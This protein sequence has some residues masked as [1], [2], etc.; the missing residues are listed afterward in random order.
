MDEKKPK[1]DERCEHCRFWRRAEDA[2][3][4]EPEGACVRL[5]PTISDSGELRLCIP[6]PRTWGCGEY[7]DS[8]LANDLRALVNG[9]EIYEVAGVWL[10]TDGDAQ[11]GT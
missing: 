8:E 3:R 4:G 10:P 6:T 9:G 5:P 1:F 2:K 7:K 11:V